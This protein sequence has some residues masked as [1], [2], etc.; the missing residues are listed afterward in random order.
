MLAAAANVVLS[1]PVAKLS[2][3][4]LEN[5]ELVFPTFLPGHDVKSMGH[6]N[7]YVIPPITRSQDPVKFLCW[8]VDYWETLNYVGGRSTNIDRVNSVMNYLLAGQIDA[9]I[10]TSSEQ[11][12]NAYAYFLLRAGRPFCISQQNSQWQRGVECVYIAFL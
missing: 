9:N 5:F 2:R 7:L 11:F 10:D 3:V 1:V 8:H 6:A 4:E 12:V